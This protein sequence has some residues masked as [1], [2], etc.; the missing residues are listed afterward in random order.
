MFR[1]FSSWLLH[2][3]SL[4][5]YHFCICKRSLW[6]LVFLRLSLHF[7]KEYSAFVRLL[8]HQLSN[9]Y[10]WWRRYPFL[11]QIFVQ[12]CVWRVLCPSHWPL[13][14]DL[15]Y[16]IT[17]DWA[18]EKSKFPFLKRAKE[19]LVCNLGVPCFDKGMITALV[20]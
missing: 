11:Y 7:Y 15:K 9:G 19:V 16:D 13:L 2:I 10:T 17:K 5:I 18:K 3:F 4:L 6:I 20:W 1:S 12:N 14:L 8:Y